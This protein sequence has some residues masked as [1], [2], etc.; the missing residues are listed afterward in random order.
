MWSLILEM[1]R[2]CRYIGSK[3][4]PGNAVDDVARFPVGFAPLSVC[5]F[6]PGTSGNGR[7]PRWVAQGYR[8]G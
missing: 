4:A 5:L 1:A 2:A 6:L 3:G 7:T 8:G